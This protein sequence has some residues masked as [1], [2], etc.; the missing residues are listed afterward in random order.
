VTYLAH[1]RATPTL[2][3]LAESFGLTNADSISNLIRPEEK[4]LAQS[5]REKK[6]ERAITK[7]LWKT[8]NRI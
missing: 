4:K 3:D 7:C 8:E 2:R 6:N 5:T 1:R